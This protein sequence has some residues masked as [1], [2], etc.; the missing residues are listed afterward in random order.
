M[1][2]LNS[3]LYCNFLFFSK[4]VCTDAFSK[5]KKLIF[6]LYIGLFNVSM[7]QIFMHRVSCLLHVRADHKCASILSGGFWTVQEEDE[8][9][10][11]KSSFHFCFISLN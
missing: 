3:L 2:L 7:Q 1:K 9:E 10:K 5:Q 4:S 8:E 6:I 11:K